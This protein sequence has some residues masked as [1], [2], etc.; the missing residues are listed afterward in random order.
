[1]FLVGLASP[2]PVLGAP[3][4]YCS[5]RYAPLN[6]SPRKAEKEK[7]LEALLAQVEVMAREQPLLP[8][9]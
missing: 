8:S 5:D 1:M 6:L 9:S 4:T 3:S 2:W 7:T